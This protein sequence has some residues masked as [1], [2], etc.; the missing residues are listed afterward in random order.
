MAGAHRTTVSRSGLAPA[1]WLWRWLKRHVK[2]AEDA[3]GILGEYARRTAGL[4]EAGRST[5]R[6]GRPRS[7]VDPRTMM[8]L[9]L[10]ATGPMISRA[11][12]ASSDHAV[13][14]RELCVVLGCW[15]EAALRRNGVAVSGGRLSGGS[16]L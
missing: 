9:G 5:G 12:S 7:F 11:V 10:P 16:R 6:R 1:V 13:P 14:Y 4:P 3:E 2:T 15:L 8:L